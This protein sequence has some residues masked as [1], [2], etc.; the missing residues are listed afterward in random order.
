VTMNPDQQ[1]IWFDFFEDAR[2]HMETN[3]RTVEAARVNLIAIA[4]NALLAA[5]RLEDDYKGNK[6]EA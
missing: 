5:D 3:P 4:T 1:K 2:A 6:D